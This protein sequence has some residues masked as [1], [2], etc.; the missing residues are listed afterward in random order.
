M[1]E[2]NPSEEAPAE[3]P[4]GEEEG[5]FSDA[6]PRPGQDVLTDEEMADAQAH[7]PHCLE[8]I[9]S[10]DYRVRNETAV[11]PRAARRLCS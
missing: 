6:E 7:C 1:S 5:D 4:T 11:A 3:E 9:T 10:A 8:Q 2:T